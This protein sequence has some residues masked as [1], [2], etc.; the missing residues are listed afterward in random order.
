MSGEEDSVEDHPN[1]QEE[2]LPDL[3]DHGEQHYE[4]SSDDAEDPESTDDWGWPDR[5]TVRVI[6]LFRQKPQLY[7]VTHKLYAHRERKN[8]T[9]VKMASELGVS[10]K[11][12]IFN[13]CKN[14]SG[15]CGTHTCIYNVVKASNETKI[16]SHSSITLQ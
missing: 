4:S 15:M 11:C 3:S 6:E 10:G 13:D 1:P 16:L 9:L 5:E 8:D 14:F 12:F 2:V 7:D